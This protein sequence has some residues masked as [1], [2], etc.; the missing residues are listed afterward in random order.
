MPLK[1]THIVN[2]LYFIYE[3]KIVLSSLVAQWV[4]DPAFS[5]LWL[6]LHLWLRFNPWPGNFC[7]LPVQPKKKYIYIC[8]YVYIYIHIYILYNT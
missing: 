1:Q 8:I 5:L 3:N 7:K 2:Q 4:K 6:C